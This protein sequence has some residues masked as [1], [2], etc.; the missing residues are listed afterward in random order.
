MVRLLSVVEDPMLILGILID[1]GEAGF[2]EQGV[3]SSVSIA[4]GT[5]R[6]RRGSGTR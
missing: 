4:L 5:S 6:W 2:G 1:K 3:R